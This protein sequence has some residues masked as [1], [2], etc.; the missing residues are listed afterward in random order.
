MRLKL[1]GFVRRSLK[2]TRF[3]RENYLILREFK[4]FPWIAAGAIAFA[5]GA[6]LFEGFGFGFLLA[7]CKVL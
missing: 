6:A 7:F 5:V 1:P 4:Y 2:A 3:W